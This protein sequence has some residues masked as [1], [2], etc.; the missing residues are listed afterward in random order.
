MDHPPGRAFL[1]KHH[2]DNMPALQKEV[3]AKGV[4][5]LPTDATVTIA[6]TS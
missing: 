2:G 1:R 4:V 5:W 3:A 6:R